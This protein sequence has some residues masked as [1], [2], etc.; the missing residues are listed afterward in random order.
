MKLT[1]QQHAV[2]M[3]DWDTAVLP[4]SVC[5]GMPFLNTENWDT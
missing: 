4:C 2:V 3:I 1:I 5:I